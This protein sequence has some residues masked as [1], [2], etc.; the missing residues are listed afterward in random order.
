MAELVSMEQLMRHLNLDS[1]EDALELDG[2][3]SAA[4]DVVESYVGPVEPRTVTERVRWPGWGH[5]LILRR[6]PV[7]ELLSAV[8]ADGAAVDLS[9]AQYGSAGVVDCWPA[10]TVSITYRAGRDP[11]PAALTLAALVIAG[12]LWETQRGPAGGM[13]GVNDEPVVIGVGYAVPNRAI[14]LMKPYLIGTMP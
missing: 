3:R 1:A 6:P 11:I 8:D 12:H 13:P 2:T 5:P 10:G 7:L 9:L 4:V 14:E